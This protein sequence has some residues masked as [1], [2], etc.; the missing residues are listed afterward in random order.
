[1]FSGPNYTNIVVELIPVIHLNI[2]S[3][4]Y[5]QNRADNPKIYTSLKFSPPLIF[6]I[7]PGPS[8]DFFQ[9]ILAPPLKFGWLSP[10]NFEVFLP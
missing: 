2:F 7:L 4:E 9:K 5:D 8:L 1:M 6:E 3:Y 10:C